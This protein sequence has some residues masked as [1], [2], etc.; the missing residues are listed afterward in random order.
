MLNTPG[1]LNKIRIETCS[2]RLDHV[3]LNGILE[4]T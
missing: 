1:I 4:R 3:G 2:L